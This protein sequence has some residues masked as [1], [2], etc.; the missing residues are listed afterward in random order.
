MAAKGQ[1][2]KPVIICTRLQFATEEI[3]SRSPCRLVSPAS[4]CVM[5]PSLLRIQPWTDS[6]YLH[7]NG[8]IFSGAGDQIR[9]LL[10]L[11]K[12][13]Q[14]NT[15]NRNN[16]HQGRNHLMELTRFK[17]LF[18]CVNY[19]RTNL[20]HRTRDLEWDLEHWTTFVF[21]RPEQRALLL[22]F[23]VR[24]LL[25]HNWRLQHHLWLVCYSSF[26]P[27]NQVYW[28][29]ISQKKQKPPLKPIS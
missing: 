19:C 9:F 27:M 29:L 3:I 4:L 25:F 7:V 16:L 26:L 18:C 15:S 1:K 17:R 6:F 8:R 12:H 2:G 11:Q 13:P 14:R 21:K 22:R 28:K 23:T 5:C 10:L 20:W 24:N